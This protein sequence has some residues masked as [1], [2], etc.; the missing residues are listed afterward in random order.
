MA[1]SLSLEYRTRLA[2]A[3]EEAGGI[4]AATYIRSLNRIE[5]QRKLYQNI[6]VMK[7]KIKG[8]STNK[9]SV[10]SEHGVAQEI[11]GKEKME[12]V[13]AE[14]NES[15]WHMTEGGSQLHHKE[16]TNKLGTFGEGKEYT[17]F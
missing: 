11:T 15:Q 8:G 10:T 6:K 3:K 5:A 14:S 1:V 9:V 12:E 16:F 17:M 13:I 4:N 2:L 7:K